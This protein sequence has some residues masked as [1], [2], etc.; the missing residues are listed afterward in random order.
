MIQKIRDHLKE[1]MAYDI[2]LLALVSLAAATNWFNLQ[3]P[4]GEDALADMLSAQAAYNSIF[5]HHMLPGWTND[6]FLGYPQF[7]VFSPLSSF[8]VLAASFPF[9]WVLGTKLLLLSFFILSGVFAYFYVHEL[10]RNRYASLA[11]GLAYPFLP[12]HIIDAVIEGHQGSFGPAYMLLPLILLYLERLIKKPSIKYV[13][14]N[15][16]LLA[17]LTLTFPQLLPLL[18]GPFLV[19][20]IIFRV[21][22]ERYRGREYLRTITI[23]SLAAFGLSLLLSAFWWLPLI[24]EIR[25]S[26]NTCFSIASAAEYSATF[27]QAVTLRPSMF[28]S[29][30][31]GF[32]AAGSPLLEILRFIP[33]ILVLLGIVL[34]RRNKYVCFFSVSILIAVLLAMGPDSPLN[35]FGFAHR[36]IPLFDR[37]RTPVRFLLFA[38]LAYAVLIGFCVHAIVERLGHLHPGK[39]RVIGVSFLVLLLVSVIIVGNTW[40]ET[41]TGFSTFSLSG[42]QKNALDWLAEQEDGDY[43][44]ADPPFDAYGYDANGGYIIRPTYWTYLHGKETV[45]GPGLS[46]AVKYTAGV[47]ESLNTDIERGPFDM[48]QWLS[49]FNVKY[50]ILDKTNPLS[51]NIILDDNFEKVWTSETIDIYENHFLKPRVFSFSDTNERRIALH[52]GATVNL[53]YAQGTQGAMLSLSDEYHLSE[54]NSV[55]SS[56]HLPNPGDY[57]SLDAN[58]EVISLQR[59]DAIRFTYYSQ[60]DLPGFYL[61]LGLLERDGS[62]YSV[63]LNAIYGIQAGWNEVSFPISLLNLRDSTDQNGRLDLDEID[64]LRISVAREDSSNRTGEFSLYFEQLSVVTQQ[65]NTSVEDTK[66]RPGKYEVHVSSASPAHLVLSE[67]YHPGWIAHVNGEKVNSQVMYECLNSFDLKSGEYDVILEFR[68]PPLRI[69]GDAI[70]GVVALLVCSTSVFLLL[71]RWRQKRMAREE[72]YKAERSWEPPS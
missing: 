26:Y 42:D 10:T 5:T 68:T 56:Y 28:C 14:I 55:K 36:Y 59:N 40:Q 6:W 41:R 72:L 16:V 57:L 50:V 1:H 19:L 38:S 48:S 71:R 34:N 45:Y 51:S 63:S 65:I 3:L 23:S 37:L 21:W 18:V 43:R 9:G 70:S 24:S 35:V 22:W 54:S 29:P 4:K 46:T 30:S 17:F 62:Q 47:L 8:L 2:C 31:S 60:H 32:G 27:L 33:V 52:D 15:G 44:I 49:L 25:Y 13:L 61:S 69:A 67:S 53:S 20:Y 64:H 7:T 12:Y 58:V 66:I 11:A 39:P